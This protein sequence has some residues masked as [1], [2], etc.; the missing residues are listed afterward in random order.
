MGFPLENEEKR[1][2]NM[3]TRSKKPSD[4]TQTAGVTGECNQ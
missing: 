2:L 1:L 3:N 4:T